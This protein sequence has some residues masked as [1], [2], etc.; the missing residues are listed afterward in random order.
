[1]NRNAEFT[2][3][4]GDMLN[5]AKRAITSALRHV[6]DGDYDF[7]SSRA[8][9]AAFYSMEAILLTRELTYSKHSGVISGFNQHF[10]SSRIFPKDFSKRITRLFRERQV[11]DY[12][13]DLS[14]TNEDAQED[15]EHARVIVTAIEQYLRKESFLS[16]HEESGEVSGD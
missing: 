12:D 2:R 8:Y 7:A 5:K 6:D 4:L 11:A 15:V 13:F 3:Q 16:E 14:I 10:V 9:Y 1:M